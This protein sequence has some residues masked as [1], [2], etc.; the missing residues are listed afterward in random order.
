[1]LKN[2]KKKKPQ[3]WVPFCC[4]TWIFHPAPWIEP[5]YPPFC[6]SMWTGHY[7]GKRISL[8]A[9]A[10][11]ILTYFDN[12]S[13]F[14]CSFAAILTFLMSDSCRI[15]EKGHQ[16]SIDRWSRFDMSKTLLCETKISQAHLAVHGNSAA[17]HCL[18]SVGI[19]I[20]GQGRFAYSSCSYCVEK[21]GNG[22][23][24]EETDPKWLW[25][26]WEML[27]PT[28]TCGVFVFSSVSGGY[29]VTCGVIRSYNFSWV[30]L[31]FHVCDCSPEA[32]RAAIH[33]SLASC[34]W[35]WGQKRS[36]TESEMM[37]G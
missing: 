33:P 23:R 25:P 34:C 1:M 4:K 13:I 28:L 12:S 5:R 7:W 24:G 22:W 14:Q 29:P 6:L 31:S 9:S 3:I 26:I 8:G 37:L 21:V 10:S 32:A 35:P 16:P 30:F 2:W 19:T 15:R 36:E 11:T 17:K 18:L 20:A 27:F